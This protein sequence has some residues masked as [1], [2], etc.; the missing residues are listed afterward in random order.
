MP[1]PPFMV[2]PSGTELDLRV[3]GAEPESSVIAE[4]PRLM[5]FGVEVPVATLEHLLLMYLYSN[6]RRHLGDFAF[7]YKGNEAAWL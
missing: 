1:T 3:A 2:G 5:L 6:Q 7:H 4:A